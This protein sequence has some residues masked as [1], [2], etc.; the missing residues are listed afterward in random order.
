MLEAK[1]QQRLT[2]IPYLAD[3]RPDVGE[4]AKLPR[5]CSVQFYQNSTYAAQKRRENEL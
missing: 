3:C 1:N 2:T 5:H 4:I